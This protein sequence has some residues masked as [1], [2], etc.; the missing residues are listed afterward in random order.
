MALTRLTAKLLALLICLGSCALQP[1]SSGAESTLSA[2]A[3]SQ[4]RI[5]S[6]F[7]NVE[8]LYDATDD[9][10][11]QDEDFTPEGRFK[12]TEQNYQIKLRNLAQVLEAIE[13]DIVGLAEVENRGT[14]EALAAHPSL[15]KRGYQ[16]VHENS[17]DPRGIDVALLYRPKAFRY[18]RHYTLHNPDIT[19]RDI[20]VVEGRVK[21]DTPLW[22]F[23]N[24]W[25]SRREGQ[26]ETEP[27]R[28]SMAQLLA[29]ETAKILQ[30]SP[31]AA[32]LLMGDFNDDPDNNS[33]RLFSEGPKEQAFINPFARILNP[34]THGSLVHEGRWYLFDQ[35]LLSPELA[36]EDAPLRWRRDSEAVFSPD[37]LR[38]GYGRGSEYPKR[39]IF[40]NQFQED[41]YSDHFPVML[42]LDVK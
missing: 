4:K 5:R 23:V 14:V 29:A 13:A 10:N 31:D 8:N 17:P 19:S 40:R 22:I 36:R 15:K 27:K 3:P 18:Q 33:L 1:Q 11:V 9:S 41:G 2:E 20:L 42:D 34:S 21:G 37:W 35:I 6:A 28:L 32:I 26:Q 16:V 38:V 24:H 25:P 12:W 39:S 7:Y 30:Q